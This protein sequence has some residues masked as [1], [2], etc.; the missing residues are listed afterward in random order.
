MLN[1]ERLHL[2]Q[3]GICYTISAAFFFDS[4]EQSNYGL[5]SDSGCAGVTPEVPSTQ[6][7]STAPGSAR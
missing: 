1:N 5:N 2:I 7:P 4:P 6:F 3:T